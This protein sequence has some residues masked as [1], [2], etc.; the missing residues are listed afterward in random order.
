MPVYKPVPS[1]SSK[2]PDPIR[3][4][5]DLFFPPDDPIGPAM[6][7]TAVVSG[8]S[9]GLLEALK[10]LAQGSLR[11]GQELAA[12]VMQRLPEYISRP[13]PAR[14]RS[15]VPAINEFFKALQ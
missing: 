3:K 13:E 4:G 1:L 8:P 9:R 2:L 5:I 6:P 11:R 12:E 15:R 7:G 14:F 10:P